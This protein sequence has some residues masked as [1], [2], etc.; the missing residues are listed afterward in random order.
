MYPPSIQKLIN[1]FSKFPTIGPRTATRFVFYLMRLSG[2][3][4]NQLIKSISELREKISLCKFCFN[5]FQPPTGTEEE[6]LCEICSDH[7]RD[8]TLLCILEKESDLVSLEKTKKYKGLY[9]I[10]GGTVSTLKKADIEKLRTKELQERIKNPERFGI[11]GADFKEIIIAIN[12]TTEG[13][14]TALYLERILK[15]FGKKITRLGRGLPVGGELE[16]A[17]EETLSS[18]LEGRK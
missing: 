18:A 4:I 8:K 5:P 12:P 16:Y 6:G 3:E 13:E 15:S 1:L 7:S 14:T 11:P 2:E 10:L 9:F 17:D